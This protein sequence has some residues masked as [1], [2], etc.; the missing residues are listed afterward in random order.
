MLT[1]VLTRHGLTDRSDPEQ[2]LGQG[3]D[4]GLSDAGRLQAVALAARIAGEHFDRI[5][6]SPL[7]RAVETARMVAFDRPIDL[8]PR[9]MEM[10]YGAWEGLTYDDIDERDGAYRRRWEL[11]PA[12]LPCPDG[13]SAEDVARRARSFLD[14]QLA[15]SSGPSERIVLAVAHSSLNR[16]LCCVAMGVPVGQY[17]RRF[18]QGQTNITVLRYADGAAADAARL[19]VLNDLGHSSIPG[20]APWELRPGA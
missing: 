6:S 17:R 18:T 12:A 16:V 20:S 11:D 13:E 5:V 14:D 10:D 7:Q 4:I 8:D 19:L 9:L 3:I 15:W 2:H 1:L